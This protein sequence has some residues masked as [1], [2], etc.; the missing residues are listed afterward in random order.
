VISP[1][2]KRGAVVHTP[3]DFESVLRSIELILGLR[4][5]NLFD[6]QATP[7]YDAF[8]SRA[9]NTEAFGA[10]APRY[11]ILEPNPA[12][13]SSAAAQAAARINTSLPDRLSQRLLDR[14]LWKSVHGPRSEPPPPGPGGVG[15]R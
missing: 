10:I 4:P 11:P 7:M 15:E 12:H 5:M 2:A 14:V 6:A 9:Q 3:Y 13:P 1:Y 8:D